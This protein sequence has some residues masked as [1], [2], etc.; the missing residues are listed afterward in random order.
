MYEKYKS[1]VRRIGK[2]AMIAV[3]AMLIASAA[4]TQNIEDVLDIKKNEATQSKVTVDVEKDA[5]IVLEKMLEMVF[6][7]GDSTI[8]SFSIGKYEVTQGMW[9]AVMGDNPSSFKNGDDYPV[10]M[11][12]VYDV[13]Q[14]L[15]KLNTMTGK[16]YRLPLVEEWEYA[17]R[18]GN[19]SKGFQYSGSNDINDV[20]WYNG[21]SGSRTRGGHTHSVGEKQP[22]ELGIHDMS[23]NVSEICQSVGY[24]VFRG[25]SWLNNAG[26][27]RISGSQPIVANL[28]DRWSGAGL[29]LVLPVQ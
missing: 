16:N 19:K 18:G 24:R 26:N 15:N 29:R 2:M 5:A 14:F 12:N 21:N 8:S 28:K 9:Q 23:G 7:E 25:G 6:V 1:T 27:C 4:Y 10:E 20:A 17:A 22:N 13:Q 11:L 3:A